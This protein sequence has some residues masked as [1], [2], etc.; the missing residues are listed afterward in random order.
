MRGTLMPQTCPTFG[1]T[2]R[3]TVRD[4]YFKGTYTDSESGVLCRV[5]EIKTTQQEVANNN[6]ECYV[7]LTLLSHDYHMTT[8]AISLPCFSHEVSPRV[9]F[10]PES[11]VR[12]RIEIQP[13]SRD[14]SERFPADTVTFDPCWRG[15][16]CDVVN[17]FP[18]LAGSTEIVTLGEEPVGIERSDWTRA[19]KQVT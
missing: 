9:S 18:S 6:T 7:G 16:V 19:A 2:P 15:G 8:R 3:I 10:K 13:S 4:E 5:A 12:L 1:S 14:S 11:T 17:G